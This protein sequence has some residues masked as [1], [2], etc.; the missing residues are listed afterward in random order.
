[1][2]KEDAPSQHIPVNKKSRYLFETLKLVEGCQVGPSRSADCAQSKCNAV[3]STIL[4][5][6]GK[7]T[8]SKGN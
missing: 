5:F 7:T 3:R 1:M 4:F 6:G 2:G 8:G